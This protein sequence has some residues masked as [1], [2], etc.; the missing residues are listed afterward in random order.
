MKKSLYL[1]AIASLIILAFT[2]SYAQRILL[3]Q[4]F[5]NAGFNS[6]SLPVGWYQIDA[7]GTGTT[8]VEWAVRDSGEAYPGGATFIYRTRAFESARSLTIG[9]KAGNPIADDWCFTDSLNIQTGD[10]LIF[11]MTLGS[12]SSTAYIDTMQIH[13]CS[14]Q[15]PIF[16]IQ[17]LATIRSLDSLNDWV[18]YK[19]NL[20]AYAGQRI[21]LAFRYWMNTVEDGLLCYIDNVF[22]GNRSVI[23]I[24]PV[25][26]NIPSKFALSQNYPNPFNPSTKITFDLAKSTNV[27][28]T[29]FNSVGQKVL[30]LF[31]GFKSAGTYE[32]K[33]DG[34]TLSSGTYYYRLE[35]DFFTETKKMQLIK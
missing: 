33:F 27:K 21:Y 22:V 23:G 20:S 11:M 24:S 32:A 8:G 35:T 16:S 31:D 13:V 3:N 4:N 30:N 34:S 2:N 26:T 14:D 15:D 17:K 1:L 28:L 9:W 25:G 5:E 10:S 12:N 18:Q 19:F 29:V 7:D 6:D